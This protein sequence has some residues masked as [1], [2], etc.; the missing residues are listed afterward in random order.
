[1]TIARALQNFYDTLGHEPDRRLSMTFATS[2]IATCT[3]IAE[4]AGTTAPAVV[5]RPPVEPPTRPSVLVLGGTGFIGQDV[6]RKLIEKGQGVRLLARDPRNLPRGLQGLPID[7]V[8]GDLANPEVL[9]RACAGIQ[10]VMHLARAHVKTWP[11]YQQFEIGAIRNVAEA[12]LRA[13]V[14]R[15]IYTGTIDS[16]YTGD[17]SQVVD[18]L[19][20]TDP[21]VH[22]RNLYARAKAESEQLLMELHRERGLPVAILR[23]GIVLGS[24][25]GPFHWGVGLWYGCTVCRLWGRGD[26][27]LPI[28]LV[29]DVARALVRAVD[30]DGVIG[31]VFNLVGEPLLT[32]REYVAELEK[33]AGLKIDTLPTSAW[34]FYRGDLFKWLVKVVVHHPDRRLPSYRDWQTRAHLAPFDCAKAKR[35]LGWVPTADRETLVREGIVK[36]V[37]EW[38]A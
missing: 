13:G 26:T 1:V 31:E 33:A 14:E 24:G 19:V 27:P 12:C 6:I 29:E 34:R 8:G 21:K 37:R 28:V 2:I 32:G 38:L 15:L 17:R 5:D 30:A 3:R 9:D 18:E 7:A 35:V 22:R 16:L 20:P 4:A 36:P 11:E 25:G 10:T 23:P